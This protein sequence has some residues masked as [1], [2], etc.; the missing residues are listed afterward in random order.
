MARKVTV[1]G[2]A[3]RR[4]AARTGGGAY[5]SQSALAKLGLYYRAV[6][7]G[8]LPPL[9]MPW[10]SPPSRFLGAKGATRPRPLLGRVRT[11]R[12]G[13][14]RQLQGVSPGVLRRADCGTVRGADRIG[15]GRPGG[16]AGRPGH[17]VLLVEQKAQAAL[18][19]ADT[20]SVL[21]RGQVVMSAPAAEVQEAK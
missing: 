4:Q 21:V 16:Y 15:T 9:P 7:D 1:S 10:I 3:A 20:A 8:D 6:E 19:F 5:P 14:R 17:A 2:T 11:G 12:R 18:W 13:V